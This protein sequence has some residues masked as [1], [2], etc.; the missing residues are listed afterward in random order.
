MS[1]IY[2]LLD[3]A[4]VHSGEALLFKLNPTDHIADVWL[5]PSIKFLNDIFRRVIVIYNNPLF[6]SFKIS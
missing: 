1:G 3:L 2:D 5:D 6:D 4:L